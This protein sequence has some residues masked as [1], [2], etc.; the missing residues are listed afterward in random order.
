MQHW[1]LCLLLASEAAGSVSLVRVLH[2]ALWLWLTPSILF[3]YLFLRMY[4]IACQFH[5][6]KSYSLSTGPLQYKHWPCG[7]CK[8]SC[9]SFACLCPHPFWVTEHLPTRGLL[10]SCTGQ[11]VHGTPDMSRGC[12]DTPTAEPVSPRPFPRH[13]SRPPGQLLDAAWVRSK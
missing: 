12:T 10:V 8:N 1:D 5:L 11:G 2:L 3:I 13:A 9:G 7:D 6:Y 4:F